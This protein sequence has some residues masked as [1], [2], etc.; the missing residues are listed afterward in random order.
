MSMG[1]K[2]LRSRGLRQTADS[3]TFL[4]PLMP[5]LPSF[6]IVLGKGR[7]VIGKAASRYAITSY[8]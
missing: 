2:P 8:G 4:Y 7:V 3:F 1:R 5:F 6:T